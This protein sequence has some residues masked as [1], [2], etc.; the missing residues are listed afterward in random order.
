MKISK[1]D[2]D[3][4]YLMDILYIYD[5]KTYESSGNIYITSYNF[6][7][8]GYTWVGK[9]ETDNPRIRVTYWVKVGELRDMDIT[10]FD[11]LEFVRDR[12]INRILSE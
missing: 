4:G 12:K 10:W 7:G 8:D 1:S 2:I 5:R 6:W 3:V 11:Y 9:R